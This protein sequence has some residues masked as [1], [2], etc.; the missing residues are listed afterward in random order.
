MKNL[1]IKISSILSLVL[2]WYIIYLIVDH[3]LLI[4]PI[5]K[6]IETFFKMLIESSFLNALWHTA[7]RLIISLLISSVCGISLGYLSAKNKSVEL[8][9]RPHVT[10]LKTIPVISVIIIMYIL[11]GYQIA[12]YVITF[13]MIFPIF[14]QATY[15]GIKAINQDLLDV[16]HLEMENRYLEFKYVYLQNIKDYLILASYQSFG[17]G[18]KVLVTSEFITQTQNSI[19]KLLYQ[20]K[21]NL[22]YDYV[23]AIT[24]LLIIITVL[25]EVFMS[26]FKKKMLQDT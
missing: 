11:V 17:L 3:P 14:Y 18:F 16:Y 12:P 25:V 7:F 13:F 6:V 9:L 4:P 24:I 8:V 19:G 20:A 26:S 15:Q 2:L 1:S 21:V 5:S 10:I 22:A 23:F